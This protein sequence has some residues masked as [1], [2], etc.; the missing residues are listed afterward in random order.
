MSRERIPRRVEHVGDDG[1]IE[2]VST[3]RTKAPIL[4]TTSVGGDDILAEVK[5]PAGHLIGALARGEDGA[6]WLW[7]QG[8]TSPRA[9]VDV[10][11]EGGPQFVEFYRPRDTML[12]LLCSTCRKTYP[13]PMEKLLRARTRTRR[14]KIPRIRLE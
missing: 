3:E 9:L 10:D 4:P 5:D 13:L 14:G 2:T 6:L 7:G 11:L 8:G 12:D 1:H